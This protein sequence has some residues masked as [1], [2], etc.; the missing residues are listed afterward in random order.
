MLA[1]HF[2]RGNAPVPRS[3]KVPGGDKWVGWQR[4]CEKTQG[5][6]LICVGVM[7]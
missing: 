7:T 4:G 1:V 6:E 3:T 5:L 2:P